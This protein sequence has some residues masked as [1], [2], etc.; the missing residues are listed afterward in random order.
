MFWV[1]GFSTVFSCTFFETLTKNRKRNNYGVTGGTSVPNGI[2]YDTDSTDYGMSWWYRVVPGCH[3]NWKLQTI[4][5]HRNLQF[6]EHSSFS[7]H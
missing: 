7:K 1:F 3:L 5:K 6:G 2:E 4:T